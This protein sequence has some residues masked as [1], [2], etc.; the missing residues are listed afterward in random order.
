MNASIVVTRKAAQGLHGLTN[1]ADGG[2]A[3]VWMCWGQESFS[4][5]S[6]GSNEPRNIAIGRVLRL[7]RRNWFRGRVGRQ[8]R[9]SGQRVGARDFVVL[10][11]NDKIRVAADAHETLGMIL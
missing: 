2:E 11:F 7:I 3:V 1:L 5:A 9:R 8:V 6:Q 10:I 4:Q